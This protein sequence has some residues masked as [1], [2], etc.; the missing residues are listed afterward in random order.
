MGRLHELAEAG[1]SIWFDY[2]QRSLI[3][4]GEL[5]R[6]I[7]DGVRGV[8]SNPAIFEQ[9]VTKS[10]DYDEAVSRLVRDGKGVREIYESIVTGD[11][12]LASGLF[13]GVY[14]ETQGMD[15]YVSVEVD[16]RLAYDTGGT[17]REA[18][19]L[20][21]LLARPNVMIKVPATKEGIPAIEELTRR[22]VNVNATLIFSIRR[23]E[24]VAGAYIRGIERRIAEGSGP[25]GVSSVASFFVSRID[26]AVDAVLEEKGLNGLEGRAAVASARL[27][28]S[29]FKG[30]FSGRRWESLA[31]KGARVQR[32]LWAS[33]GTKNPRYPDTMYVD[34][35][36]GAHTVNTLPPKTLGAF[37][38]HGKTTPSIED[39]LEDSARVL[40][41]IRACG[42]DMDAVTARLEEEGVKAFVKSF[43][44]LL[45]GI[46][47]K[48][49]GAA[50]R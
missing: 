29:R 42:I 3:S 43:D 7:D 10:T 16:P 17:V 37:L 19:R 45:D 36:V 48:S 15:G 24:E 20:F 6:L 47:K 34:S 39:D 9:A 13:T 2:I 4:S 11:I 25:A 40:D 26:T 28:Y 1:Q 5:K 12:S 21:S 32:P 22:G 31:A 27:V 35:L 38:D 8:T 41:E 46:A 30:I 23:Y 14:A 49:E 50:V 33:T 18:L 44:T